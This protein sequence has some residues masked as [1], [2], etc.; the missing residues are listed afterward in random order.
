MYSQII[1][2]GETHIYILF[3]LS[4]CF[5][6]SKCK[7]LKATTTYKQVRPETMAPSELEVFMQVVHNIITNA[8]L[9]SVAFSP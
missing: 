8:A 6:P 9:L 4:L 1:T 2:Y 5:F 7:T 3:L